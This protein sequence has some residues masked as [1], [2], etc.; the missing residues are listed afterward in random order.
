MKYSRHSMSKRTYDQFC[1]AARALDV[2]GERWTLLIVRD[3]LLGPK[4]YTDLLNGLPGIGPNVL[5]ARLKELAAVG[6]VEQT[7]LP[8]PAASTVYR[9]TELGTS[10]RPVLA[11]LLRWGLNFLDEPTGD[12]SFRAGW[13]LSAMLVNFR[14]ELAQ[15]LHESYEF[16]IDGETLHVRIDDGDIEVSE[17]PAVDPVYSVS[18]DLETFLAVSLREI[19]PAEAVEAGRSE[20]VG[21]LEAAGRSLDILGPLG[22]VEQRIPA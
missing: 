19:T 15:G 17:G 8:P 6:I 13:I 12:D 11:E 4:R 2:V 21:D 14:P 1:P 16:N 5:A 20:F 22:P 10:L 18:S 3:L 9:L 7:A